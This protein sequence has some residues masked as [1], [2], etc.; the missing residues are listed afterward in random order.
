MTNSKR[1]PRGP[2]P[3]PTHAPGP[4]VPETPIRT[5]EQPSSNAPGMFTR[6]PPANIDVME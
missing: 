4:R 1:Q 6:T 2:M 3:E 5:P